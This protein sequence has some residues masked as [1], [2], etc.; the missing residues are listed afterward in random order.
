MDDKSEMPA[1]TL[2][3]IMYERVTKRISYMFIY[4]DETTRAEDTKKGVFKLMN[5]TQFDRGL[6]EAGIPAKKLQHQ[7]NAAIPGVGI[8]GVGPPGAEKG[9]GRRRG[10]ACGEQGSH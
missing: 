9:A 2:K 8:P 7:G 4:K 5:V 6:K 3:E 1:V 10:A